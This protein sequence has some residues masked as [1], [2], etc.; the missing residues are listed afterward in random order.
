MTQRFYAHDAA[1][2]LAGTLPS[3]Y[4]VGTV[5]QTAAGSATN[6]TMDGTLG[7][8]QVSAVV[9]TAAVTS[10]QASTFRRFLSG[11]L[12][13]QT[14]SANPT[15]SW[16]VGAA[17]A[18]ANSDMF[19]TGS[20][21]VYIWRPGTGA[22]VGFLCGLNATD[23]G[24]TEPGTTQTACTA[25]RAQTRPAITVLTGDILVWELCSQQSQAMGTGY[26]N[27]VFY[28]G[29]TEGSVTDIASYLDLGFDLVM[30]T[31]P[32]PERVPRS[33]PYPQLL[34]N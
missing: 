19:E 6:R 7:A 31:P 10:V 1:T 3:A 24:L 32:A 30:F 5:S 2:G 34:S 13:A 29:A 14:I 33:T 18:N 9:T 8:A 21:V 22:V 11:A 15:L 26:T 17:E 23:S 4:Q 27:T 28:D 20:A 16:S 25:T 12:A